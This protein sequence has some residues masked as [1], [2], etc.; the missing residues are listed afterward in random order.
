MFLFRSML[1]GRMKHQ[2]RRTGFLFPVRTGHAKSVKRARGEGKD[3]N[4]REQHQRPD[5]LIS[6]P[7]LTFTTWDDGIN[8]WEERQEG[9]D[10]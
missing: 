3:I 9:Y 8:P 5:G 6:H 2:E 1:D 4:G 7:R 10:D